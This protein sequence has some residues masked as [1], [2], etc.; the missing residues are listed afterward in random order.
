MSH[1]ETKGFAH[2]KGCALTVFKSASLQKP[3]CLDWVGQSSTDPSFPA[4]LWS[5]TGGAAQS[6]SSAFRM[7]P[8]QPVLNTFS[9]RE[10]RCQQEIIQKLMVYWELAGCASLNLSVYIQ[11]CS[12]ICLLLQGKCSLSCQHVQLPKQGF[13][14]QMLTA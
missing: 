5:N 10:V 12:D 1:A 3:L 4:W 11:T 13:L 9:F 7:S 6:L 8:G 2:S 14:M